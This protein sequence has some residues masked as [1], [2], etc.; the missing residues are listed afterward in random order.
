MEC[1]LIQDSGCCRW[2]IYVPRRK[3][4][5]AVVVSLTVVVSSRNAISNEELTIPERIII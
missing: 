5:E 2:Y 4:V 3:R 1:H